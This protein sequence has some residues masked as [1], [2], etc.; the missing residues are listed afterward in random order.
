[1]EY[2][3]D[4]FLSPASAEHFLI[5]GGGFFLFISV[6]LAWICRRLNYWIEWTVM[7]WSVG[8][9]AL[10][11]A[12]IFFILS[13]DGIIYYRAY[14]VGLLLGAALSY[15]MFIAEGVD[16]KTSLP[17]RLDKA[18][19]FSVEKSKNADKTDEKAKFTANFLN[20]CALAF[21]GSGLV[22]SLSGLVI[23][24]RLA[25]EFSTL[26]GF[27]AVCLVVAVALHLTARKLV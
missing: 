27:V 7:G 21:I 22:S 13:S 20:S 25:P 1:M 15:F 8:A 23:N 24:P 17:A 16:R 2:A 18:D 6:P 5:A 9:F 10:G 14:I 3:L 19:Y 12:F 11:I 4:Y 26:A